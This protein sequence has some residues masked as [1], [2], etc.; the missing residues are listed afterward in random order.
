MKFLKIILITAL[1][2][3]TIL[4][5]VGLIMP[6]HIAI[7]R[8]RSIK[9]P[10][11]AISAQI[12]DLRRWEQWSPWQ[13]MDPAIKTEYSNPS[14]GPGAYSKWQSEK[15]GNGT[16][17]LTAVTPDSIAQSMDF[18]MGLPASAAFYLSPEGNATKVRWTGHFDMGPNPYKHLMGAMMDSWVGNDYAKGLDN[19]A[20]TVEGK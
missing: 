14:G 17:T 8:T 3:V 15:V 7:E 10:R 11:E 18:G 20:A 19:L 6:R 2:V 4:G 16:M 12:A 9:A 1:S 13:K 5:V